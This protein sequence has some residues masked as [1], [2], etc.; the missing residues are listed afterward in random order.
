MVTEETN[1]SIIPPTSSSIHDEQKEA[2]DLKKLINIK[3]RRLQK[4]KE[5]EAAY[6][7]STDPGILIEIEKIEAELE[8][9]QA[10]LATLEED[11]INTYTSRSD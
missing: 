3:S 5:Q 10:E 6:G 1:S 11:D 8:Q 4:L 2:I 9:L 7:I